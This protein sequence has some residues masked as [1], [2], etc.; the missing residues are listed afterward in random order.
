V[1]T[2]TP[3][4]EP[5]PVPLPAGDWRVVPARSEVGFLTRIF[6]LIPVRGRYSDYDGELHI[7]D[8]GNAR[9]VLRIKAATISTGIKQRDQHLRSSDF[10][11]VEQHPH[12]RFELASLTPNTDGALTLTGTLHI[13][14]QEL[15]IRTPVSVTRLGSDGMRL[16]AD[17]GVGHRACGFES[18]RL[19]RTVRLQAALTLE[20]PR[21]SRAAAQGA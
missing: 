15:P 20:R 7:D 8:A 17:F 9:G 14:D 13:R 2:T 5:Q 6:G 16:E 19:P 12:L 4:T 10:F 11:A 21:A 18:K 1:A 3:S